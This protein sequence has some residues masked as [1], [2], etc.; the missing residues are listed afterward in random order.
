MRSWEAWVS[1]LVAGVSGYHRRA[2]GEQSASVL[3]RQCVEL[4]SWG[5]SSPVVAK[6]PFADQV[7]DFDA[8]ENDARATEVFEALYRARDALPPA[9]W[10]CSTML[11]KYLYCRITTLVR[12]FAL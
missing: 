3:R 10:S 1:W 4:L 11:F 8:A 12:C 5:L 6:L 2:S 7:H 9:R